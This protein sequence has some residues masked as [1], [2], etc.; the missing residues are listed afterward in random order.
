MDTNVQAETNKLYQH[1][2]EVIEQIM[3][4]R[5][6]QAKIKLEI[7]KLATTSGQPNLIAN[8]PMCW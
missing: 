7:V 3:K 4:L 5:H 8:M 6:E 1:R 2:A